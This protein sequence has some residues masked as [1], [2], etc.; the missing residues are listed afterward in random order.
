MMK[1]FRRSIV[2]QRPK[3]ASSVSTSQHLATPTFSRLFQRPKRASSVSTEKTMSKISKLKK[4]FNALN[5]LLPFLPR[6]RSSLLG[7]RWRLFQ[8]P[9]RASSISTATSGNPH[10][11]WLSRLV[12]AGICLN[13]LKTAVFWKFF[14][15]FTFCSYFGSIFCLSLDLFFLLYAETEAPIFQLFLSEPQLIVHILYAGPC[16]LSN[17]LPAIIIHHSVPL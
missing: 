1:S 7:R 14:G 9:K 17:C 5:G 4:C 16:T 10:K 6:P 8:R 2:F 3:R 13:I 12:F 15:M 11:H